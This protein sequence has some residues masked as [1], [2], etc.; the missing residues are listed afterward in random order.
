MGI[1]DAFLLCLVVVV[2]IL[3]GA[4]LSYVLPRVRSSALEAQAA[5]GELGSE[6]ERTLGAF[7]LVK[8][9]GRE[10]AELERIGATA[11]RAERGGT[12]LARWAALAAA[13][14]GVTTQVAFLVVLGLGGWRVQTG[15]LSV[16]DLVAFLLYVFFLTAPIL[17][18]INASM[19]FQTGRAALGRIAEIQELATEDVMGPRVGVRHDWRA[20]PAS[21][22]FEDVRFAYPG[23]EHP[24]VD[25]V[26][27]DLP[28]GGVTALVGPSGA[29]KSTLFG[30]LE[31]FYSPDGGRILIDGRELRDW[32]LGELRSQIAYVEQNAPVMAGTLRENLTYAAPEATEEEVREVLALCRLERFVERLGGDLDAEVSQGGGSLSGGERQRI[33]I[34]RSLL[35]YPRLLLL[36]EITSQ[37][38]AENEAAL[39]DLIHE[40]A[41]R[42]TVIVAAH[43]LSTVRNAD[44]IVVLEDGR[45]RAIG[46]HEAL[47]RSDVLYASFAD[48]VAPSNGVAP[49]N[50]HHAR[51]REA[52]LIPRLL[53]GLR[54]ARRSAS[55]R[56][57]TARPA[58]DT[59]AGS[60]A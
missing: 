17:Q 32:P 42:T 58:R 52:G 1:L 3:L 30:L 55:R 7:P 2:V 35:R 33:A 23:S 36:D 44:R 26:D 50:G 56:E 46:P 53:E 34:A 39:R 54:P 21:V 14:S 4:F 11:E 6:L 20:R 27:L 5:V 8:A 19:Y 15:A 10:R 57:D 9:S 43:R 51:E 28:S 37:L 49:T 48:T 13:A 60:P 29:G 22:R 16:A 12:R 40:I 59:R 25:G 47:L 38:D 18:L 24:A 41:K 31:R 45:I